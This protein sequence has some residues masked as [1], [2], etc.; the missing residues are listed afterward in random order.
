LA[1]SRSSS[2]GRPR[3]AHGHQ[4]DILRYVFFHSIALALLAGL[5]VFLHA[6][7]APLR[8]TIVE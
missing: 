3:K 5:L 7:A 6:C 8:R 1:R 2:Q 4:G